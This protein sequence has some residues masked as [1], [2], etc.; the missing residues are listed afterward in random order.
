MTECD[1]L[2][3][4]T[5][6]HHA[7]HQT[8]T[9]CVV[10]RGQT[11][12]VSERFMRLS[13]SSLFWLLGARKYVREQLKHTTAQLCLVQQIRFSYH[14]HHTNKH[15]TMPSLQNRQSVCELR[16]FKGKKMKLLEQ[17]PAE[18]YKICLTFI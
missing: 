9:P 15:H 17:V 3:P 2:L 12:R 16:L 8:H 7:I 1:C 4:L 14:I 5:K 13:S 11:H 18:T 10:R 6:G